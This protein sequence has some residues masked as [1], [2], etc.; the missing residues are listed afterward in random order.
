MI[1]ISNF[2]RIGSNLLSNFGENPHASLFFF[3]ASRVMHSK[4][5]CLHFFHCCCKIIKNTER[6][7]RNSRRITPAQESGAH[8]LKGAAAGGLPNL[9][10]GSRKTG[11]K[12]LRYQKRAGRKCVAQKRWYREKQG[13]FVLFT[14]TG[15]PFCL[16][17]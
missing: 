13:L 2:H 15:R 10:S 7:R 8:R 4:I 5:F 9:P 17:F 16:P 12:A 14:G 1:S 3:P 6:E 11:R